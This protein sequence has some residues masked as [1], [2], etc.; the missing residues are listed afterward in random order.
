MEF[1]PRKRQ[2]I[3][4]RFLQVDLHVSHRLDSICVEQ[5]SPFAADTAY[6]GYWL[7]T[8][9]FVVHSHYRHKCCVLTYGIGD[10]FRRY[11]TV[12]ISRQICD[13]KALAF[14][15][16]TAVQHSVMLDI[17]CDDV[18]LAAFCTEFSAANDR[19][20]VSL[21]TARCEKYLRRSCR[22]QCLSHLT[23]GI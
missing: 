13:L 21:R 15:I 9:Y 22:A 7:D 1:M 10:L 18:P 11:K 6:L 16:F 19:H 20:V 17:R 4:A 23:A 12:F 14:E 5:H 8:A 3:N 2:H